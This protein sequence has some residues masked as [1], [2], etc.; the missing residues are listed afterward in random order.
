M[1]EWVCFRQGC[2]CWRGG[3]VRCP[4][5][6]LGVLESVC[7][8]PRAR[9]CVCVWVCVSAGEVAA[10]EAAV[11]AQLREG[12]PPSLKP[13]QA[14]FGLLTLDVASRVSVAAIVHC[15]NEMARGPA[16]VAQAALQARRGGLF[17][18]LER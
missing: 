12:K 15:L 6:G 9:V 10:V 8:P 13:F 4:S 18:A 17:S 16:A 3:G 14:R 2:V 1:G 5:V 11:R 7:V